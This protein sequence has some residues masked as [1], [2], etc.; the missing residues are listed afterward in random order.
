MRWAFRWLFGW[1]VFLWALHDVRPSATPQ[2]GPGARLEPVAEVFDARHVEVV[3]DREGR[4]LTKAS[5]LDRTPRE[6]QVVEDERFPP[7]AD[8][9]QPPA[10]DMSRIGAL[11]RLAPITTWPDQP[12]RPVD[13]D[14]GSCAIGWEIAPGVFEVTPPTN[15]LATSCGSVSRCGRILP[16]YRNGRPIGLR[17]I[18]PPPNLGIE[19]GDVV[20]RVNGLEFHGPEDALV[21]YS[22]LRAASRFEVDLERDGQLLKRTY[23]LRRSAGP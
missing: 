4:R 1:L 5:W 7:G 9:S 14:T 20:L 11:L 21:A 8:A 15:S 12:P 2:A 18:A 6:A 22:E 23:V 19:S 17:F 10:I 16:A 13:T 3:L